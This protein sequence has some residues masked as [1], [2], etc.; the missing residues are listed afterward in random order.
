MIRK[1]FKF[2]F[3]WCLGLIVL[4]TA[5]TRAQLPAPIEGKPVHPDSMQPPIVTKMKGEP[6]RYNAHPNKF[7]ATPVSTKELPR[8]LKVVNIGS[9]GI[10]GPRI[11]KAEFIKTPVTYPKPV[12]LGEFR[13]A[14]DG[15]YTI[16]SITE[17][18]GFEAGSILSILEDSRGHI[19]M[20][21]HSATITRLD[22]EYVHNF[23]TENGF[24][25]TG[26]VINMIEDRQGRIWF[27]GNG[28]ICYFDG[29]HVYH[30]DRYRDEENT[31]RS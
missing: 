6:I 24:P 16:K 29:Q 28:G 3:I 18:E 11:E 26:G 30:Y 27:A 31:F 13:V 1:F 5:L 14:K 9:N 12:K 8:N 23:S 21:Q 20:G 15:W 17:D 4:S 10:P 19:W 25:V 2:R 7:K 22:G